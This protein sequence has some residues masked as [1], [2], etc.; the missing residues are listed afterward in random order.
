MSEMIPAHDPL[1]EDD[2]D[3]VPLTYPDGQPIDEQRIAWAMSCVGYAA[4]EMAQE[5]FGKLILFLADLLRTGELPSKKPAH[6]K[7]VK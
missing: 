5:D 7:T 4:G 3:D 1:E 2:E 6:L